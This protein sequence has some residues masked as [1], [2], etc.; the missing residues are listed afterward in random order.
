ME[1]TVYTFE[2]GRLVS[3]DRVTASKTFTPS[4]Y[5]NSY[6]NDNGSSLRQLK[7]DRL[8]QDEKRRFDQMERENDARRK[9]LQ[10]WKP[11]QK[12]VN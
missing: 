2:F 12:T 4:V 3:M 8:I 5:I 7:N 6:E 10:N 9:D 1:E 11:G